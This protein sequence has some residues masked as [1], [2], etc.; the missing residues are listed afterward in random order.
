[1]KLFNKSKLAQLRHND[2][3]IRELSS[4]DLALVAGGTTTQEGKFT[5]VTSTNGSKTCVRTK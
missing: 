3:A 1:M 2:R 4:T 5:C